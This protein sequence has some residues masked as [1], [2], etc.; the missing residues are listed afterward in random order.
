MECET[1]PSNFSY[2]VRLKPTGLPRTLDPRLIL[3][4]GYL[5]NTGLLCSTD[6]LDTKTFH[7]TVLKKSHSLISPLTSSVESW[8]TRT[9]SSSRWWTKVSTTL[10][11]HLTAQFYHWQQI[12]SVVFLEVTGPPWSFPSQCLPDTQ[13]WP[14]M[15]ASCWFKQ[16]RGGSQVS[17]QRA[18][19]NTALPSQLHIRHSAYMYFL[20][21]HTGAQRLKGLGLIKWITFTMPYHQGHATIKLAWGFCFVLFCFLEMVI[22][23][24]WEYSNSNNLVRLSWLTLRHRHLHLTAKVNTTKNVK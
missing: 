13:V 18:H 7:F 12:L 23:Q 14:T 15:P 17:S 10:V 11:F 16:K 3:W 4:H 6:F 2:S 8:S 21:C 24:W 9:L 22:V 20:S 19:L 1:I 5:E